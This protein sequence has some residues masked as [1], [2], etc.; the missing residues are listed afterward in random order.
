MPLTITSETAPSAT[1]RQIQITAIDPVFMEI[2]KVLTRLKPLIDSTHFDLALGNPDRS[3]VVLTQ[4]NITAT[5]ILVGEI[6]RITITVDGK[7]L[8]TDLEGHP[9][10]SYLYEPVRPKSKKTKTAK[11]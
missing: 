2:A 1:T 11:V 6:Y 4:D 7:P 3:E 8:T 9:A 5:A 10:A